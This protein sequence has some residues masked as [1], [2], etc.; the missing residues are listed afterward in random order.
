MMNLGDEE[1][2]PIDDS[3][4][5]IAD[6]WI[7]Q[8]LNDVIRDV[9]ANLDSYD[10]NLAVDRVYSFIW[11]EFCDWYVEMSKP[12]LYGDDEKAKA[13]VRSVLVHVLSRSL[14][15]LHPFMPFITEDI[16]TR[17]PGSDKTIMLSAWPKV[18]E[19][20]NFPEEADAMDSLMDM[21][22]QIRNI[23]AEMNVPPSRRAHTFVVT[24]PENEAVC[25]EA[26][27][28]L[29]KLAGASTVDVCFSREG[30]DRNAVSVVSKI[31]EACIPM[32]ELIDVAK[33]LERLEK[34]RKRWEG[35]VARANGKL[36]NQ[37]FMAKAPEKV[38]EEERAKLANAR[39][40]L[41]KLDA[42]IRDMKA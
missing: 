24:T 12:R 9:T 20:Y 11:T 42:R 8:R 40:M 16:Y 4:L 39:E 31:G 15:L 22:R 17:L 14:K 13:H 35:E 25:R 33:E 7:L 3:M 27:P 5:D 30:I 2:R 6:K 1:L 26:A 28:Y 38:V 32:N 19:K 21:V 18:D 37:G 23:R 29:N 34:E 36:N 10:L 41:E